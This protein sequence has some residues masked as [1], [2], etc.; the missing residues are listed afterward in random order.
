MDGGDAH[1]DAHINRRGG[2]DIALDGSY[3]RGEQFSISLWMLK[4]VAEPYV[5]P[6]PTPEYIYL[7]PSRGES[8]NARISIQ[9]SRVAWLG[10][11]EL[12]VWMTG[13]G[14]RMF[15]VALSRDSAPTWTHLSIV[16]NGPQVAAFENG[17]EQAEVVDKSE[18]G[19][20]APTSLEVI[21][22]N[23]QEARAL[24]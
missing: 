1:C 8:V 24:C 16:V 6:Q 4:E 22:S 19:E 21:G 18:S 10:A 3:A 7:H 2:I 23:Y 5:S 11:W 15:D 12:G 20:A 9:V 13:A 14:L 17:V